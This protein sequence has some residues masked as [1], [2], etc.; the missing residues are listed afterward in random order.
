MGNIVVIMNTIKVTYPISLT[1]TLVA[2]LKPIAL[3]EN[4]TVFVGVEDNWREILAENNVE[5]CEE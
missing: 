3:R 4:K 5:G 2:Q 1:A